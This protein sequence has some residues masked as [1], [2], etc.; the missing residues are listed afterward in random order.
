MFILVPQLFGWFQSMN[1]VALQAVAKKNPQAGGA[2]RIFASQ[3]RAL[4]AGEK[5]EDSESIDS[6]TK[7]GAAEDFEGGCGKLCQGFSG[8][9]IKR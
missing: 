4:E 6:V 3:K 5:S 9:S 2:A 1:F 8:G 7:G